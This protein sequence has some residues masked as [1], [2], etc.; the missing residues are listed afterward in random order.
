LNKPNLDYKFVNGLHAH[1]SCQYLGLIIA[2][3]ERIRNLG[4][5]ELKP[6]QK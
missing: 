4:T 3:D 2:K 6:F 1:F 5:I